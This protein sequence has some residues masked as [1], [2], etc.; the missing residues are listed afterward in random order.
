MLRWLTSRLAAVM[1]FPLAIA[2]L[3]TPL[4]GCDAQQSRA[5]NP[6]YRVVATVGMVSDLVS[7]VAGGRAEVYTLIGAGVDPHLYKPTRDDVDALQSADIIFYAGLMLEGKMGDVLVRMA[8]SGKPT[9]AVTEQVDEKLLLEPEEM[10][11]H[12]DP[13]L[14]MDVSAWAK[15]VDVIAAA[16]SKFD[17]RGAETYRANA[18]RY[19]A[20]LEKLDAYVKRVVGSIPRERRVLITAHDAFNYFGRAYDIEVR[21]IQGISTESEAGL[22]DINDLV[23]FL[24]QRRVLAVFVET[25]VAD[26]N[27]R[28]LIEGAAARGHTLRIGGTLFSDAMGPAGTYEGTYLGMLDHNATVI[29]RALG[30]EAP[31][32]GMQ[33]RLSAGD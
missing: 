5:A 4:S 20:E 28:A 1:V 9:Y 30:G 11:G 12:F 15:T 3:S 10:Q 21:G 13:H 23:E 22:R 6:R 31:P 32:R 14:W 8:R 26:K 25:S 17:P 29:T 27:V 16:L 7:Q 2:A 19:Q 24:V 33:A 18:T